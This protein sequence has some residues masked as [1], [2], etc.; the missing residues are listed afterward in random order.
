MMR[1]AKT[2]PLHSRKKLRAAS[3]EGPLIQKN[4]KGDAIVSRRN[5]PRKAE[6]VSAGV[7]V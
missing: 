2:I 3:K 5:C 6:T 4:E 7:A 1:H